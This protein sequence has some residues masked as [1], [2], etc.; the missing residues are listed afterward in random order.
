[1]SITLSI[2]LAIPLAACLKAPKADDTPSEDKQQQSQAGS[3]AAAQPEALAQPAR[4]AGPL[5]FTDVTAA[6][7]IHFKHNSG[8]AGKKYL[9]ETVG[10]GCAFLD[11]DN[12]GF[13]DILI[14]NSMGWTDQKGSKNSYPALYHN[15]H[16]G[17]F[18]DVTKEAGLAIEIYGLG[19]A[20]GD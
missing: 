20:V 15:N 7:G 18:T 13:Q 12:D 1:I 3:Q 9:P 6:A 19:C 8:A 14:I 5:Q 2:F 16:N 10:S 17:T 11:Y 4:Y